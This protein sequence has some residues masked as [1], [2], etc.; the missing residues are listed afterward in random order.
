MKVII[1]GSRDIADYEIVL[2]AIS[3]ANFDIT[4]VVSGCARGI[5][6]LGERF[7][8]E[9][10]LP[11]HKFPADWSGPHKRAAGYIRNADMANFADALI[12]VWDGSSPGTKSMID[13]AK[14]NNLKIYVEI[15][16]TVDINS[17]M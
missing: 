12:A 11:I 15:L 2:L 5:D 1:A 14:K 3:N 13:L 17:Q 4:S 7:A 8:L 16:K 9:C 6:K 10:N